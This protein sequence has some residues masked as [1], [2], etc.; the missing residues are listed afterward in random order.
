M[1]IRLLPAL[2]V[3]AFY[4]MPATSAKDRPGP[5]V[6]S[7]V[8]YIEKAG[9]LIG[10]ELELTISHSQVTGLL[11]LYEG[12]CASPITV[13]GNLQGRKLHLSGT[14]GYFGKQKIDAT[15][16]GA[17]LEGTLSVGK[18]HTEKIVLKRVSQPHCSF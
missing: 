9:D 6:Y 16:E 2:L 4:A 11:K 12:D 13:N 1:R 10:V 14:S 5:R 18:R 7:N 3:L 17:N 15:M 8:Q